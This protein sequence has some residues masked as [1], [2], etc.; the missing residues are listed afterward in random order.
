MLKVGGIYVSPFEVEAA[1][2][3]HEMVLEAAVVGHADEQPP[4][5]A[6]APSWCCGRGL[7]AAPALAAELQQHVKARFGAVQ[8]SALDR[9][10]ARSAEDRHRQD[11]AL[12]AARRY[13]G[14]LRSFHGSFTLGMVSISTLASVPFTFSTWRI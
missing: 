4:R 1:L 6:A 2:M 9:I 14:G 5:Q 8:I 12:Q 11:P 13:L 7:S 10:R 3:T